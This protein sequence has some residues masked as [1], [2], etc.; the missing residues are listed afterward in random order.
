[1][2]RAVILWLAIL[3]APAAWFANLCANFALAPWAC[4]LAWKPALYAVSAVSVLIAAACAAVA[5]VEWRRLGR[6]Y[7]GEAAGAIPR[8]RA[9][10]S[11]GVAL[12]GMFALVITAQ[13]IA[14]LILR[15]C[16]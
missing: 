12:A 16:D 9:L 8:S 10:A 4:S 11:G 2:N 13:A 14:E 6:E 7:P 1:M 5:W 15:A 3:I